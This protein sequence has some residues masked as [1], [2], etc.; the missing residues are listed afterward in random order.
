M[1]TLEEQHY[2]LLAQEPSNA[3]RK[4]VILELFRA[5]L[6]TEEQVAFWFYVFGLKHA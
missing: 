3:A 6:F 4:A 1:V 2:A 5:G